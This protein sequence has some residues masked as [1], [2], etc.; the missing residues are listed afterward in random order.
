MSNSMPLYLKSKIK[1]LIL[2]KNIWQIPED[3]ENLNRLNI[4]DEIVHRGIN[5][6]H[7]HPHISLSALN[8]KV[9]F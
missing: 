8:F 6:Y 5:L 7:Y 2:K 1:W 3:T 9:E 4:I